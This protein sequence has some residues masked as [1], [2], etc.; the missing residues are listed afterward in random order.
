MHLVREIEYRLVPGHIDWALRI[1][2]YLDLHEIILRD[3]QYELEIR[4]E[5]TSD[6]QDW[7]LTLIIDNFIVKG[8]LMGLFQGDTNTVH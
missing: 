1:I 8:Y 5:E 7:N 3:K 6:S 2:K 4:H